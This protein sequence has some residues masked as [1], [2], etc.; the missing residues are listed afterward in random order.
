[1]GWGWFGGS[2]DPVGRGFGDECG[3]RLGRR[4]EGLSAGDLAATM[5]AALGI[6]PAGH[7][8]DQ[9]GRPYAVATG[10]PITGLYAG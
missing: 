10:K 2:A 9:L 6:D 8:E 7:Y 5:F 1:M 3:E 4:A